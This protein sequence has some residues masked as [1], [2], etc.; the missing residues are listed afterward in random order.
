MHAHTNVTNEGL[1]LVVTSQL[2]LHTVKACK[3]RTGWGPHALYKS[4]QRVLQ[5]HAQHHGWSMW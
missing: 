5:V 2:L 4:L 1:M 3:E